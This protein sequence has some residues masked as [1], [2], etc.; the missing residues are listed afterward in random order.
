MRLWMTWQS[1]FAMMVIG[2]VFC[3]SAQAEEN[4]N[5]MTEI[6]VGAKPISG[7]EATGTVQRITAEQIRQQGADTLDEALQLIP[8]V[9][10]R[11]G[12]EGTPRIDIRGFRTRHVQLFINGIP[13]RETFDDQFDPTT[14]PV[15]YIAEIKV[16]TGGGSVLYGQGGNGGAIDIITKK[17]QRGI[18]GSLSAEAGE[19]ER[20][21]GRGTVG[22]AGDKLDVFAA[23]SY[24]DRDHY[25]TAESFDTPEGATDQR[26][27]SDRRRAN[28]FGNA[29]YQLFEH[30]KLGLTAIHNTGENGKPPV[31]NY[32]PSDPFTKKAKYQRTDNLDNTLFQAA[33][34]AD[35]DGP[36]RFRIWGYFNQNKQEDNVY[37]D[38][39]SDPAATNDPDTWTQVKKGASHE[40]SD[41]RILGI[42]T[43]LKF[44]AGKDGAAA[45]GL[46]AERDT[47]EA[48]GYTLT[49][50][51]GAQEL[52]DDRREMNFYS[53][54]LEYEYKFSDRLGGVIGYGH[55]F[56]IK[57][58][59]KDE[60]NFSYL[61][62]AFFD[63]T[64]ST[65][66]RVNHARKVRFP[67]IKQLYDGT[68]RN[69][70]LVPETTYHYEA[71]IEQTLPARSSLQLT[72]FYIKAEDFIE[73]DSSDINQNYQELLFQGVE[74]A[75]TTKAIQNAMFRVAYTYL[76][77][78]DKSAGATREELQYRP[79]HTVVVEGSYNFSFG[80][81]MHA[82]LKHVAG[83]YFYDKNDIE[84][85][86]LGDFTVVN[87]KLDQAIGASDLSV[88]AGADNLFDENYEESYGLPQPG[89]TLYAGVE[90]HF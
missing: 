29:A 53:A 47:W 12:A 22:G 3:G 43:Q 76:E 71:G 87:F 83:Q 57:D 20:Y 14:I 11:E 66:L 46:N 62:G 35:P 44:Q 56:M 19:G 50:N 41:T 34:A 64:D 17:G 90:Y 23:A 51:S 42:S 77:T 15:E 28:F 13:I 88:Y 63:L 25:T 61:I 81:A 10:I 55:H 45:L 37:D 48:N 16:T 85:K 24:Y 78:E 49:N 32:S 84:K 2:W 79:A 4:A 52:I 38:P 74:I 31:T 39:N 9:T 1:V 80:L 5:R 18:Q 67:S 7:S 72:G 69:P 27:N 6:V 8:G 68:S 89:R 65:L 40:D 82:S 75:M 60:N 30:A 21:I 54:A 26:L 36:A 73:K 59:G 86:A 33:L 58:Q 70:D